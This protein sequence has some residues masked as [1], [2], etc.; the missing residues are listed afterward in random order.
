MDGAERPIVL[1]L[2]PEAPSASDVLVW[3][4]GHAR[5]VTGPMGALPAWAHARF[6]A[7]RAESALVFPGLALGAVASRAHEVTDGMMRAAAEVVARAVPDTALEE[8][9]L[10]PPPCGLRALAR[11]VAAAVVREARDT[12]VGLPLETGA[13]TRVLDDLVWDP[14]YPEVRLTEPGA[15]ALPPARQ[16]QLA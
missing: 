9:A 3:T 11:L 16:R 6:G 15:P 13:I 12:G 8:G 4:S 2:S 10:L 7:A 1:A 14:A 5:V